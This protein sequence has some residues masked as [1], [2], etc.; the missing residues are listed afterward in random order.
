MVQLECEVVN[1][2]G[3]HFTI[4]LRQQEEAVIFDPLELRV[5]GR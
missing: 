3:N 2:G 4:F 1:R 5:L